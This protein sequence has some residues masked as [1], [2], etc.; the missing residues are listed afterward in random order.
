[1]CYC[2]AIHRDRERQTHPRLNSRHPYAVLNTLISFKSSKINIQNFFIII[3]KP[4]MPFMPQFSTNNTT[5]ILQYCFIF[6]NIK[7]TNFKFPGST[8]ASNNIQQVT[9]NLYKSR[10]N[11]GL[12]YLPPSRWLLLAG[13]WHT[14]SV[15]PL[16]FSLHIFHNVWIAKRKY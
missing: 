8:S 9:G 5:N 1:M 4:F 14:S 16:F 7:C 3:T 15:F 2:A 13:N 10:P 11:W 6:K 12:L